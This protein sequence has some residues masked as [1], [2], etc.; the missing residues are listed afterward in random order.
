MSKIKVFIVE[1][2]PIAQE[3]LTFILN[4]DPEI[5]VI[6]TASDGEAALLALKSKNPD[7]ILMDINMPKMNGF[8]AT[9]KIME[10]LPVPIVIVSAVWDP[11]EVA[12][13]FRA[14]EAGAVAVLEK[15]VGI[16]HP[17]YKAVAKELVQT[18]KLMS[19]AKVVR[20]WARP[21]QVRAA[22]KASR[23]VRPEQK[24]ADIRVVAIGT[25]TGGPPVLQTILAGLAEDF[26]VPVLIV[27]HIASGFLQGMI[28]WLDQAT[29]LQV[30]I[31]THGERALPG[32]VYLAPD[33]VH[34]GM[35]GNGR[36]TLSAGEPENGLRP[37]ISYLFR[38]VAG[39]F[40]EQAIG[41]LLTGMGSDGAK[42]LKMLREKGATTIAQDKDSSVVHGLAG[43][44][45]NLDA[46]MY[47]HSPDEI[48]V[49][50]ASLVNNKALFRNNVKR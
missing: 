30:R 18:V 26:P 2:S 9:R 41:I 42:E 19:E 46:A 49:M 50:L 5:R 47:V 34:M 6:G 45:I 29:D 20:R 23:V 1:D 8:V 24:L 27:Q 14:M 28:R 32:H 39:A 21:S 7:V 31:A 37:S 17:D 4:S 43:A 33:D 36:I 16:G 15:P 44:A 10:T 40:G 11:H 25:S 48:A 13:T 12:T 38:S 22:R 3:F 35:S